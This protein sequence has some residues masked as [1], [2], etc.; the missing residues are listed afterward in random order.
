MP[1]AR[2]TKK[3]T[4]HL[5]EDISTDESGQ[6]TGSTQTSTTEEESKS[7][8]PKQSK[9]S[10]SKDLK[11]SSRKRSMPCP[12]GSGIKYKECCRKLKESSIKIPSKIK[13]SSNKSVGDV[14]MVKKSRSSRN[15]DPSEAKDE[16]TIQMEG[17]FRMLKI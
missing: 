5:P 15:L 10:S 2:I 6:T 16:P 14:N 3:T 12:C 7:D 4:A 8:R 13:E 17:K 11:K 1:K 9:K